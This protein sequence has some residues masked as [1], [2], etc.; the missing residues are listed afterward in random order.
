MPV[1]SKKIALKIVEVL[2]DKKALDVV[3]LDIHSLTVIADYFIIASGRSESQ[4]RALYGEVEEKMREQGLE[5]RHRDGQQGNRWVV[6]DYGD[7]IL[8][9]FH[10]E[11]RE[12]YGLERLWADGISLSVDNT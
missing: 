5:A 9:V 2:Q 11:E 6:L 1:N 4:V 12:F 8:H 3:V 7:V 10:H